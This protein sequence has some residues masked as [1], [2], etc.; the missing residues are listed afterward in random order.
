MKRVKERSNGNRNGRT[1]KK[2]F[3]ALGFFTGAMGLDLGLAKAGIKTVLASEIDPVT[4]KTISAYRDAHHP[5]LALIGDIRDY[6]ADSIRARCNLSAKRDIDL[7]F[8]G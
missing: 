6:T 8:G 5:E 1:S 7:V 2:Y 3:L 4:C